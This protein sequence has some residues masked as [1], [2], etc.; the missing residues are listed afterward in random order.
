[1]HGPAFQTDQTRRSAPH[2]AQ[3][4]REQCPSCS[5][6]FDPRDLSDVIQ[7]DLERGFESGH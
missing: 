5:Q 7:H 3:E 1:M 6:W 2:I 4:P